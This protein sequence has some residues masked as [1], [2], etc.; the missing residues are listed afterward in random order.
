MRN[1]IYISA[2]LAMVSIWGYFV[3]AM[4]NQPAADQFL[5]A[6]TASSADDTPVTPEHFTKTP[7]TRTVNA[8]KAYRANCSACHAKVRIFPQPMTA[9]VMHHMRQ[10]TTLTTDETR[11]LLEYLT[12]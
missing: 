6:A 10:Q 9:T 3:G 1:L 7:A 11:A 8:R 2:M 5:I 4:Q 12:Q